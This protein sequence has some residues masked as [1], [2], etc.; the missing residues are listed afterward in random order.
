[1]LPIELE[2]GLLACAL[3]QLAAVT[4]ESSRIRCN[5]T[6]SH[7]D[8][9]FDSRVSVHLYRIAQEAVANALRHSGA[10]SIR[11]SLA[12]ENGETAL[13]IEDDGIGLSAE[14]AQAGGMGLRTMR[15]RAGL[16]GGELEIGPGPNGG[17]RVVC[18][19]P[20]N[21]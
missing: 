10:H 3:E 19:W 11:I 1:M 21:E 12:Q 14:A 6:C 5:F 15:Y 8:P 2:E 16:I 20:E 18:R 13:R 9:V 17:T 4:S 7:P